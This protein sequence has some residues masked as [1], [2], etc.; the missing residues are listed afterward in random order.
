MPLALRESVEKEELMNLTG[1]NNLDFFAASQQGEAQ[2]TSGS[3][4]AS[5]VEFLYEFFALLEGPAGEEIESLMGSS[6]AE[7]PH[8][9]LQS[10]EQEVV[11]A[12]VS[13]FDLNLGTLE[14]QTNASQD[15]SSPQGR[16]TATTSQEVTG[17]RFPLTVGLGSLPTSG[18]IESQSIPPAGLAETVDKETEQRYLMNGVV[19]V[20]GRDLDRGVRA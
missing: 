11:D 14:D 7:N 19:S 5:E 18:Q 6:Q 15:L 9:A 2:E 4:R 16:I 20:G 1:L 3:T 13:G 10:S 8:S 12:A 17:L